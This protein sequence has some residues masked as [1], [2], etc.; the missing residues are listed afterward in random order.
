MSQYRC[1]DNTYNI[2]FPFRLPESM[3]DY[4][5]SEGFDLTCVANET[6]M[7]NIDSESYQVKS[8]DY[9]TNVLTVVDPD[10]VSGNQPCP[11]R[12]TN[13]TLDFSLFTYAA[14][15]LNL[16]FFSNCSSIFTFPWLIRPTARSSVATIQRERDAAYS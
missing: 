14:F 3:P 5:G 10:L 6:L 4:C 9:A 13:T 2:M 8:I 1:G 15:D 7:I 16:T 11:Q 12:L